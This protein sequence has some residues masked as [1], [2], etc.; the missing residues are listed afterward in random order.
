MRSLQPPRPART[1][2][3]ALPPAYQ[4]ARQLIV[5]EAGS[6]DR[7]VAMTRELKLLAAHK[8]DFHRRFLE[9]LNITKPEATSSVSKE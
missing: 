6:H 4:E 7:R 5:P 3:L 8:A 9:A 1:R 2:S